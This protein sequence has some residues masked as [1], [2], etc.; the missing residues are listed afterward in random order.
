MLSESAI[1]RNMTYRHARSSPSVWLD[2][3]T[4]RTS[5]DDRAVG[6]VQYSDDATRQG[7]SHDCVVGCPKCREHHNDAT[8]YYARYTVAEEHVQGR[9]NAVGGPLASSASETYRGMSILDGRPGELP[10]LHGRRGRR[11]SVRRLRAWGPEQQSQVPFKQW[12]REVAIWLVANSDLNEFRQAAFVSSRLA[13]VRVSS[14]ANGRGL[15]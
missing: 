8:E 9:S 12:V 2:E 15:S 14:W 7:R 5:L 4:M 1:S 6:G 3:A 13:S 10:I 11:G